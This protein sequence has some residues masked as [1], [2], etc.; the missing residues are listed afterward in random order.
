[1]NSKFL[2]ISICDCNNGRFIASTTKQEIEYI[3]NVVMK[4]VSRMKIG[5]FHQTQ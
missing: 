1:M 5:L 4:S 2:R 3:Y